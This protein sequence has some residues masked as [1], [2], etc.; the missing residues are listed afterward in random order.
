MEWRRTAAS[1]PG[2]DRRLSTPG[3]LWCNPRD[4]SP[5]RPARTVDG[6]ADGATFPAAEIGVQ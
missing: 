1:D 2:V 6:V 5:A 3:E 4:T